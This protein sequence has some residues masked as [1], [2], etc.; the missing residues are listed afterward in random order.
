MLTPRVLVLE[1]QLPASAVV[2]RFPFFISLWTVVQGLKP[3]VIDMSTPSERA[4][5]TQLRKAAGSKSLETLQEALRGW[6]PEEVSA[7]GQE[8]KTPLHMA[9][10]KGC[11]EN[12]Q[13]LVE[14]MKCDVDVYSKGQFSYGK[15]AVFF[16]A[17]QSRV[18]VMEYLLSKD[19]KV[20]IV[21]NKGQSVLSIASS[22]D[23]PP[24]VIDKIQQ[25]EKQQQRVKDDDDDTVWWNFRATHSDGLDYGDLDPRFLD[26]PLRKED[27][28]T[29]WAVNPTTKE[30]RKGGFARRNPEVAREHTERLQ[31]QQ[32][33]RERKRVDRRRSELTPEG[34]Q[35]WERL[36]QELSICLAEQTIQLPNMA[37][38]H[39]LQVVALGNQY[40][41]PWIQEAKV[42]LLRITKED[43]TTVSTLLLKCEEMATNDRT[44]DLLGKL[45]SRIVDDNGDSEGPDGIIES[46]QRS[47]KSEKTINV[48]RRAWEQ[49]SLQVRHLCIADLECNERMGS[50][51]PKILTLPEPPSFV[52][53]IDSLQELK[54]LLFSRYS[55]ATVE[56]PM[57]I[58][59]DTEWYDVEIEGGDSHSA[60]S[61]VQLAVSDMDTRRIQTFVVDLTS[62]QSAYRR[63]TQEVVHWILRSKNLLVLGFAL[64]HDVHM[65]KT[66]AQLFL[67][68]HSDSESTF[69]D[70][71]LLLAFNGKGTLPGLKKCASKFSDIPLSKSEQCSEWGNR[72]LRSSQLEYAGLDAAILLVLLS[73]EYCHQQE[74]QDRAS[75]V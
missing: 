60:L 27:V 68:E 66:F 3:P 69:L 55:E 34:E 17:T 75:V 19:S 4:S 1:H 26:R 61:T 39:M 30:T 56:R 53:T 59:V 64:S 23:M 47:S 74:Q 62:R 73:E 67:E 13:H 2:L 25:L 54:T 6:T 63:T 35:Q 45:R 57:L 20:T 51:H 72:P 65:L 31:K 15:T 33:K 18:D 43:P 41:R 44:K 5:L 14:E 10:W 24:S 36:W 29:P 16:A 49:A 50:S 40:R 11:L 37:V 46:H 70:V 22:H 38:E 28:A 21:N 12:V 48:D 71:Q 58:A 8:G 9:A 32:R 7:A 52:N 42:R